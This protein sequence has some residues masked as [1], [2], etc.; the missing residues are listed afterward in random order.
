MNTPADVHLGI[1]VFYPGKIVTFHQALE[2]IVTD[3]T[4][5]P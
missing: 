5:Q 3:G 1:H 4:F 2:D